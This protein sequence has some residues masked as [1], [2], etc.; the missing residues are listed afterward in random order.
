[1]WLFLGHSEDSGRE[2]FL[3]VVNHSAQAGEARI[4]AVDDAGTPAGPV[5]LSLGANQ[6]IHLNSRDLEGGNANKGLPQGIGAGSGDWRLSL[7]S[8]LDFEALSYV[9]TKDGFVTTMHDTAPKM[10][11]GSLRVAFLNPGSNWRQESHLR[12]INPGAEAATVRIIGTDDAG[13]PGEATVSAEL[14][15]GQSRTFT[16]AELESGNAPGLSGELGDG[17]GKWRLR[18]ES[19]RDIVAMSLLAPPTG[20]LANLSAPPPEADAAGAWA[21]P[22]FLSASD[23][24]GREGFLRVVNRSGSAGTVRIEAFDGSDFAYEP[25]TLSLDAG[26]TRHFNSDDLENGNAG[27]GLSG[28]TGAGR[29]DWRLELTSELDIQA[30]A[31]IRTKDGFVTSM[32][33]LAPAAADGLLHRVAFPQPRQQ[34][35]AGQQTAPGEPGHGG[36]QRNHRG[37]RRRRA[38]SGHRGSGQRA[39]GQGGVLGREGT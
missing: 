24:S 30:L 22:L 27:K 31:Y 5:T 39:G 19:E 32:H 2:G 6:A 35:P 20:H 11:D 28:S 13:Q 38:V 16:A 12:L 8:A 36:C 33:D 9:R 29:G 18:L 37:H 21:V 3:R 1:M 10:D 23:P 26:Q 14:P 17:A 25:V 7:T 34:L 4:E 15:A